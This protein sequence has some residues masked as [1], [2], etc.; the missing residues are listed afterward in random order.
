MSFEV[1]QE[2]VFG[3][4]SGGTYGLPWYVAEDGS[5]ISRKVVIGRCPRCRKAICR[6]YITPGGNLAVPHGELDAESGDS[7]FRCTRTSCPVETFT[8]DIEDVANLA[9]AAAAG[10]RRS[11]V[12]AYTGSNAPMTAAAATS[13]A[14]R[15][16]A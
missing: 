1:K 7:L 16:W 3:N 8:M 12:L 2:L 13:P 9:S 4:V 6:L 10:G 5:E 11:V 14:G 15:A